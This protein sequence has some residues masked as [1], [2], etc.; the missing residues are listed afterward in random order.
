MYNLL[1]SKIIDDD[2][3]SCYFYIKDT[4]EAPVAAENLMKELYKKLDYIKE[5]PYSRP[6]VYDKLLASLGIRSIKVNNYLLFY[7]IEDEENI[8]IIT[9]MYGKRD[10]INILKDMSLEEIM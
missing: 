1:F 2:I 7:S 3:D 10:W 5:K 6:L 9:F 4:L 8:N